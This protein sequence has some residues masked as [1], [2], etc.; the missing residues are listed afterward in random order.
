MKNK[1]IIYLV[2][3][4]DDDRMFAT[5]AF[6]NVLQDVRLIEFSDG[7]QLLQ[8][9]ELNEDVQS[10]S[11]ILMDINMP[12]LSGLEVLSVIR[13][14]P[15]ICHIPVILFSTSS[16]QDIIKKAYQMGVNAYI[17]KPT[18]L[19]GYIQMVHAVSLCFL[20][21]GSLSLKPDLSV[22][23]SRLKR[24]LV[25]EDNFDHWDLMQIA[26][27]TQEKAELIHADSAEK[28]MDF[29]V[30]E[31]S[32]TRLPVELIILDLYLPDRQQG[33]DLIED[34]RSFFINRGLAPIPIII[35]S[36]SDHKEDITASYQRQANA[37][38]VK[39][40]DF[41]GSAFY[42]NDVCSLWNTTIATP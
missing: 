30:S 25:I 8:S 24:I 22:I 35:F 13:S 42:L 1:A 19:E 32:A 7:R 26:L 11:F 12:F 10:P 37:Y 16:N 29:L 36:G 6:E 21:K 14:N 41:V 20:Q 23:H 5:E 38:L 9:L 15:D 27:R 39:S 2:D 33:L 40:L 17:V 34:I 28:A 4:D 18:T 3:D 31:Y